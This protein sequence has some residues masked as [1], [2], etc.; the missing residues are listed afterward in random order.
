MRLGRIR[1]RSK[2]IKTPVAVLAPK[3]PNRYQRQHRQFEYASTLRAMNVFAIAMRTC[4]HGTSPLRRIP[5]RDRK[6]RSLNIG[7]RCGIALAP[8]GR[9]PHL[10][11]PHVQMVGQRGR[12]RLPSPQPWLRGP[13]SLPSPFASN[14]MH[15]ATPKLFSFAHSRKFLSAIRAT[16]SAASGYSPL[17]HPRRASLFAPAGPRKRSKSGRCANLNRIH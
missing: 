14:F 13:L 10:A 2:P 4:R 7:T 1:R 3:W 16:R 11:C 6:L 17:K 8:F 15:R 12:E 5:I 9:P